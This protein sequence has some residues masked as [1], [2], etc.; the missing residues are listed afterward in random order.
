[1][2]EATAKVSL[3]PKMDDQESETNARRSPVDCPDPKPY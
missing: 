1:M 2:S 3:P